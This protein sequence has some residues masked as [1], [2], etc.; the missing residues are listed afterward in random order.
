VRAAKTV[1]RKDPQKAVSL[2]SAL[3]LLAAEAFHPRLETHRLR[4]ALEGSWACSAGYDLRIAFRL[5]EYE[6]AEAI[7]LETVGTHD[8]VYLSEG[9]ARFWGRQEAA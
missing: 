7:L 9:P 3:E 8:E 1:V 5:V 2:Q 6:G 4:G